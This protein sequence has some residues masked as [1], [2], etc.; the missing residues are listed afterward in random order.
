MVPDEVM[1]TVNNQE[2]E[3]DAGPNQSDDTLSC[4]TLNG[5]GSS[6]PD[7]DTPLTYQGN[8]K[9]KN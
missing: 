1:I 8:R 7:G 2:P 6:D 3:A 4:V 5:S 9:V